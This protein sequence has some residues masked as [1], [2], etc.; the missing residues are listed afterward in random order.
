MHLILYAHCSLH[1]I[2]KVLYFYDKQKKFIAKKKYMHN[3]NINMT[4][5]KQHNNNKFNN[6]KKSIRSKIMNAQENC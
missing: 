1:S 6:K 3:K 5:K 2:L 4:T